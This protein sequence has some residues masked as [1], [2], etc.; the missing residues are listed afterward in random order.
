MIGERTQKLDLSL[1][2]AEVLALKDLLLDAPSVTARAKALSRFHEDTWSELQAIL[3][4]A[5]QTMR[6]EEG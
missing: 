5:A 1:S 2:T 6:E 4:M 3:A